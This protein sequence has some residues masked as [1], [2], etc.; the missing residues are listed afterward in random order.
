MGVCGVGCVGCVISHFS[1]SPDI[2]NKA[3]A[4]TPKARVY[5]CTTEKAKAIVLTLNGVRYPFTSKTSAATKLVGRIIGAWGRPLTDAQNIATILKAAKRKKGKKVGPFGVDSSQTLT[6][7][8][9]RSLC[10]N[11]VKLVE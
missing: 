5:K 11:T 2:T 3:N 10:R 8:L 1:L 7:R 6:H 9:S 4:V